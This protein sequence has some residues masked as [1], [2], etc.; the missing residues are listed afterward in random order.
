MLTKFFQAFASRQNSEN[1]LSDIIYAACESS[2]SF[3]ELFIHFFFP[4]IDNPSE[5]YMERESSQK[6][7]RVDF[8]LISDD[9]TYIIENKIYDRNQHFGEYDKA[10]NIPPE[11]FGY[12]TNYDVFEKKNYYLSQGY[13]IHTWKEFYHYLL[14]HT[15]EDEISKCVLNYIKSV[16]SIISI[17]E[18]MKLSSLTSL[19]IFFEILKKIFNVETD[20]YIS[21]YY[22][23]NCKQ[24]TFWGGNICEPH[25]NCVVGRYF[26][27]RFKN[28]RG[29]LNTTCGWLGIYFNDIESKPTIRIGIREDK[30]WSG[31][32]YNVITNNINKKSEWYIKNDVV[33]KDLTDEEFT[34]LE[35]SN[36]IEE[37]KNILSTFYTSTIDYIANLIEQKPQ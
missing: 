30:Y 36:S 11:R 20:Q 1:D 24:E 29:S 26:E 34:K 27:V 19:T 22:I 14:L 10:F 9:Y 28:I 3:K 23:N 13:R 25:D 18:T 8:L 4:E 15:E 12:I 32:A 21:E 35:N 5:I 2:E 6:N 37:Q 31:K 33:W 16:C 17:K 7:S